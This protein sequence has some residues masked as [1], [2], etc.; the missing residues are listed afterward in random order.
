MGGPSYGSA[1]ALRRRT[2]ERGTALGYPRSVAA[3]D[4]H[5]DA[6]DRAASSLWAP[7]ARPVFRVLWIASVFSNLG[8]WIQGVGAA[9]LMTSL[10]SSPGLVALVQVASN[11]PLFFLALPAGALADVVDRRRVLLVS[12]TWML[13]AAALL[14]ALAAADVVEPWSL[15]A[16]VFLL[17]IGAALNGPAWQAVIPELVA[18]VELPSAVTLGSISFNV[19]RAAGPALGGL[20]VAAW[21]P[22]A[23]FFL[24]AASFVGVI[25]V[26]A[27]WRREVAVPTLPGERILGAMRTGV[28][29]VRYAPEVRGILVR[30]GAF[31]FSAS[32]FWALLP[33]VARR[34]LGLGPTGYGLLLG[35][36]GLGAV[37]TALA[38]P[39]LRRRLG[40]SSLVA[41]AGAL[42]AVAL[43]VLAEVR[44]PFVL[45]GV[46]LVAG[47]SWLAV[48][49][50]FNVA[51]QTAVPSWVRARAVAVY[52]LVFF[53]A[54]AAGSSVWGGV[55]E[56][57]GSTNALLAAAGGL[58]LA[59][60][61][62]GR[63]PLPAGEALNLAPGRHW[64]APAVAFDPAPDRGPVLVTVEYRIDPAQHYAFREAMR[65]LR[66]I[67]MR[68]G[69]L[70]W[71]LFADV[72]DAGRQLEVF[73]VASWLEHL[74]QHERV[75][76]ADRE[77]EERAKAF[78]RG[79]EPPRVDHLLGGSVPA[80]G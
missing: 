21:G 22:A 70:E 65:E 12:Q 24:N 44:L 77:H 28:H 43:V 58:A 45:G 14:G 5:P 19:A 49:S 31:L 17:G 64:P 48:L 52:M 2:G 9:W 20:L 32:A 54:L 26:L 73:L 4:P 1:A 80:T 25:L 8:T 34:E 18:A 38:I 79:P 23:T 40:A 41:T 42:F 53:G 63:L 72:N 55:A 27:T 62:T 66:R 35:C 29:Y 56:R 59:L 37:L 71:G 61:L 36:F 68:D 60:L 3:P 74:R 50:T 7:L 6:V 33:Q 67:R 30:G 10:T 15:L 76:V 69:A 11:L 46:M 16:L 78:H 51:V 75:T 39:D 57:W 47:S 13:A